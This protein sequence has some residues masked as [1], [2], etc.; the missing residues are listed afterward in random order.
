MKLSM[1]RKTARKLARKLNMERTWINV[2]PKDSLIDFILSE[3]RSYRKRGSGGEKETKSYTT[4]DGSEHEYTKTPKPKADGLEGMIVNTIMENLGTYVESTVKV[5][6]ENTRR[7]LTDEVADVQKGILTEVEERISELRRPIQVH[8]NDRPVT[9]ITGM[10]HEAFQQV[11]ECAKH[12]KMVLMVGEAGT[13]KSYIA[14][15]VATALGYDCGNGSKD[16]SYICGNADLTLS[17]VTGRMDANGNWYEGK[18]NHAF[19]NGG[20]LCIDEAFRFDPCVGVLFNPMTDHQGYMPLPNHPTETHISRHDNNIILFIDNSWGQGN[21]FDYVASQ[22]QDN[23]WLDRLD[24]VKVEVGYDK[25]I[26]RALV[27]DH[28][29]TGRMLWELRSRIKT[30][31]INRIL[32]TRRFQDANIWKSVGM[33][34]ADVLDKFTTGWSAEEVAKVNVTELKEIYS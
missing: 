4:K 20:A 21:S 25:Q 30:E 22:K 8:I 10:V 34:N 17:Q 29:E 7:E 15:Q 13:G 9:S 12:F 18:F 28:V 1:V 5:G 32:S 19:G 6:I 27:G 14:K 31:G 23:A 16:W 26:E 33:S 3:D 2:E 24:G 11:L